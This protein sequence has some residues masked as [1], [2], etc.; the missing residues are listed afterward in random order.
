MLNMWDQCTIILVTDLN[1]YEATERHYIVTIAL[2]EGP[3]PS[4]TFYGT[5]KRADC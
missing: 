1:M 3:C 2:T 4:V 5:S